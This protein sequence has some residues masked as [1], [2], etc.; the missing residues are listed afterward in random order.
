M[1]G[2]DG[3]PDGWVG[4]APDDNGLRVYAAPTL[5][6]LIAQAEA[7][8]ELAWIGVDIPIGLSDD[9]PRQADLMVRQWL[10]AR[11]ASLFLTPVRG[12]L[13]LPDYPAAVAEN[14]RITAAG[15][16]RQAY[17]LRTKIVEVDALVAGGE[18]R[19]F[20][21]HPELSFTVMAGRPA[22]HGKKT[23]AGLQERLN[24]LAEH[25]L[26]LDAQLQGSS[27]RAAADDVLDATAAAWTARRR[28]AGA[29]QPRPDP[30]QPLRVGPDGAEWPGAIWA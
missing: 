26:P 10:G 18:Q 11:S 19:V 21:V 2:V 8:G 15:F 4:I 22:R 13:M 23:W 20:E 7:D 9:R 24:L 30:P 29:A 3:Y 25:G 1:L 6:A 14:R 17:G 27:G 28:R 5:A 12:A 16:S